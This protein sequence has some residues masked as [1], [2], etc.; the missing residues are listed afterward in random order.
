ME[1][2]MAEIDKINVPSAQDEV[3][4]A[5]E[6]SDEYKAGFQAGKNGKPHAPGAPPR[7]R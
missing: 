5:D 3:P 7:Q 4:P 1:R 6:E 2:D